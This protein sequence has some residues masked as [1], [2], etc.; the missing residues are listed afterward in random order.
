MTSAHRYRLPVVLALL[1]VGPL[2]GAGC[3]PLKQ[4]PRSG[5]QG[6]KQ[7]EK[8]ASTPP[9]RVIMKTAKF[10]VDEP[11]GKP[12]MRA[13]VNGALG[14]ISSNGIEQSPV[15][16]NGATCT[17]YRSGKPE[18]RITAPSA[19]WKD[20]RL[21]ADQ[22]AHVEMVDGTVKADAKRAVWE[23]QVL[24]TFDTTATFYE[25]GQPKMKL[26]APEVEMKDDLVVAPKTAHA[27][28]PDGATK[29]DAQRAVW[30]RT[31]AKLNLDNAVGQEF[32]NGKQTV[33]AEGP[34]VEYANNWL[35]IPATGSARRL[36]DGSSVRADRIRWNRTTAQMEATGR[37]R[38]E[39]PG[40]SAEGKRLVGNTNLKKGKMT[41]RPRMRLRRPPPAPGGRASS[42]PRKSR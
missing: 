2:G 37:V 33:Q 39:T 6:Q 14:G 38:L 17:M 9:V 5:A 18:L 19:A 4:A 31:T 10:N 36:D 13:E 27:E 42:G 30:N 3:K 7:D 28:T 41:G 11:D 35:V 16:L 29:L 8:K 26:R 40:L 20:N 24:R 22:G 15:T 23:K 34:K 21:V 1:A 12:L 25:K 32:E